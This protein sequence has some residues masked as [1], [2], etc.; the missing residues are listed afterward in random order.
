MHIQIINGPNVN[1]IG[2]REPEIYG[3]RSLNE[4]LEGLEA[5]YSDCELSCFQSNHEGELIDAIQQTTAQA[6]IVNLGGYSH[7]SIA[8]HDALKSL[9]IPILE[10]HISN[11]HAREAFRETTI[12]GRAAKGIITGLGLEGYALAVDYLIKAFSDKQL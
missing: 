5:Q 1:L 2:T 3:S 9:P 8:L 11:I 6:L 12:T 7:T 10:V 4:Y